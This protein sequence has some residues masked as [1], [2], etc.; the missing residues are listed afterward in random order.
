MMEGVYRDNRL[1]FAL[2][3]VMW[4]IFV[5]SV[6]VLPDRIPVHWGIDLSAPDRWGSKLEL[7]IIPFVTT[8]LSLACMGFARVIK[9][10]TYGNGRSSEALMNKVTLGITAAMLLLQIGIIA[11]TAMSL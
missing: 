5:V 2:L 11:L 1:S 10:E 8:I 6:I 4:A 9:G 3:A 7:V